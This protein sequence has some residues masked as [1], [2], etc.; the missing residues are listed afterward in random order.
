MDKRERIAKH[1]KD[2]AKTNEELSERQPEQLL[3]Q[4]F[5]SCVKKIVTTTSMTGEEVKAEDLVSAFKT[6]PRVIARISRRGIQN[7]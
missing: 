4:Y 7:V 6:S 5:S 2:E 1:L 3:E